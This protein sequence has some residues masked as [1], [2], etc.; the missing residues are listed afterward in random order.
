MGR[1]LPAARQKAFDDLY[2]GAM[3]KDARQ[4]R[5]ALTDDFTFRGPMMAFDG[6]EAFVQSLLAFDADVTQSRLI[7]DGE[8]VA[9]LFVL[10]I[11][12]P[13]RAKVPMCDVLEFRGDRI[14]AIELYTDSK[15]FEP[16]GA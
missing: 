11:A 8:R 13:F 4:V 12:A 14:S 6:P 3:K 15:A 5:S 10:D 16:A 2:N 9:H 1:S 7:V